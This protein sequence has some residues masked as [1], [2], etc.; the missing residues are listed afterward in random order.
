MLLKRGAEAELRRTT[1]LGREAVEK[2][3]L[4]KGYR[5]PALDEE[6]RRARLRRVAT[7]MGEGPHGG[8]AGAPGCRGAAPRGR[9][10]RTPRAAGVRERGK[11]T[12]GGGRPAGPVRRRRPPGGSGGFPQ[13]PPPR[14]S[15][16]PAATAR[17]LSSRRTASR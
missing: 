14:P 8:Q 4:P 15:A 1:Y 11:E 9:G 13:S 12:G 17:T 10:R 16:P 5:L 2:V 7:L 6:L 3:R